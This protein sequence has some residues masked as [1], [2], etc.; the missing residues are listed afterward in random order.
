MGRPAADHRASG[1]PAPC[2]PA[3]SPP[4]SA[5]AWPGAACTIDRRHRAA[6][7]AGRA[8]PIGRRARPGPAGLVPAASR[9]RHRPDAAP[10]RRR[11]R[12]AHHRHACVQILARPATPRQ[13][14]R[15]R[16]GAAALRTGQPPAGGLLDPATLAARRAEPDH[17]DRHRTAH[18]R[19][20]APHQPPRTDAGAAGAPIRC[21]TA[22]P[23][24][25]IDKTIGPQWEIAIRYAVATHHTRA[26]GDPTTL[27]DPPAGHPRA[28]ARVRVRRL[29]PAATGCAG[30]G[31]RSPAAVLA[32]RPLRRGFL[33]SRRRAGRDRRRCRTDLAVP[34]LDRARAKAVPAPVDVPTG[35]RDTKVLGRAEVGGHTVALPVADA[36]QHIHLLG[37]TG[38]GKIHP[39]VPHGP[40]RHP[41]PPRRRRHRPQRRPRPGHPRPHPRASW[42]TGS[43]S[44]T[45]T[46]PAAPPST[47][48]PGDDHD[49]VVDNIVSIFSKIF[50]RHWGPRIDDVLRVACLTLMRKANATLTLVPPLLQRQAVPGRVHRRPRRPGRACGGSGSGTSPPRRRCARRSSAR[51]WPGCGRSCCA[52]SSAPPSASRR[53]ASTWATSSTAA[54]CSPACPKG[55]S[56]RRPPN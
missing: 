46:S 53:P 14:A 16:R 26:G 18:P 52:T 9:P 23:A 35:G 30:C 5:A 38:S 13:I 28:R 25:A 27:I 19:P 32:A 47:R 50:Q 7:R 40:R 8:S 15:L 20:A 45:P 44:S 37:S 1:C 29:R 10:G 49:L 21:A 6:A 12:P 54:S 41:R 24:P 43:C 33:L 56:A 2:R 3:R 36:R 42:P 11:R 22:T 4:R 55:R 34:G 48:S 17:R 39:D 31:C 51:C